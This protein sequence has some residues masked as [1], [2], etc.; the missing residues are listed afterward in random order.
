MSV[1]QQ[2][3]AD[4]R[5]REASGGVGTVSNSRGNHSWVEVWDRGEWHCLGASESDA[6]DKVWFGKAAAAADPADPYKR[7]Y[8]TRFERSTLRFPV[9][10]DPYAGY[11]S[12]VD[13]TPDYKVR[14]G[15]Q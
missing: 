12:A 5:K 8:A 4:A 9:A 11:I 3:D 13:V 15:Q 7:V 6:L 10:W 2:C 1:G 14:F